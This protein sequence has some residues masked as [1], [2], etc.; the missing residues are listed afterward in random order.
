ME[1]LTEKQKHI[2]QRKLCDMKRRCNNPNDKFYKDYGGRGITVCPE[3]TDKRKGHENFQKWAIGSGW[4]EG[5][6]IDRIDVNGNYEP[7]NCRWATPKEQSNNRRNNLYVT[8]HGVTKTSTEWAEE[9]GIAERSFASRVKSGWSEDRL[10]D[11]KFQPLKM[12]KAEMAKEIR[13]W[14]NAEE[15]ELLLRLPCKV[16]D[17]IYKIPS[18]V[19]YDLNI[20]NRH[21]ENNRVY[22]QTVYSIQMWN[23]SSYILNTCDVMD[24]VRSDSF[25]ETWFLTKA[26]AEK[27]LEE[28]EKE[29]E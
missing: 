5:F 14:R 11:P 25:G 17:I 28:M 19:N 21:R 16:G 22:E 18:K 8:I 27:A 7:S 4:R 12:S 3:W 10:L 13:A 24:C 29:H 23:N 1:R 26:E 6:S 2:L 20:V 15:Q 9:I